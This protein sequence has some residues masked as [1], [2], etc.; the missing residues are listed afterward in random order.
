MA[1]NAPTEARH[2]DISAG[3]GATETVGLLSGRWV[4]AKLTAI[5]PDWSRQWS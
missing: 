5:L 4:T 1:P 3:R 2:F